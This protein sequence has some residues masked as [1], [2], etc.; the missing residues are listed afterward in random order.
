M[1]S[2][3]LVNYNVHCDWSIEQSWLL[4]YE[5]AFV[6]KMS[7]DLSPSFVNIIHIK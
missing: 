6:A 4:K 5:T 2:C 7:R 3:L 1:T